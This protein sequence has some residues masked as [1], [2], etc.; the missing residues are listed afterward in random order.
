MF[1]EKPHEGGRHSRNPSSVSAYEVPR[2][3]KASQ[4]QN[5]R[6]KDYELDTQDSAPEETMEAVPDTSLDHIN[7]KKRHHS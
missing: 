5:D 1:E 2:S 6:S 3:P 7:L 4:N